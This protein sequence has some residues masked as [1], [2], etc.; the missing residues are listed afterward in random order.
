MTKKSRQKF[1]YLENGES[2]LGE[3]KNIFGFKRDFK[4]QKLSQ[5]LVRACKSSDPHRLLLNLTDKI[6]LKRYNKYVALS[7]LIIYYTRKDIKKLIQN[8]KFKIS[9]LMWNDKFYFPNGS[10]SL[11][12]IQGYFACITKKHEAVA[13]TPP[14]RIN[15]KKDI[16]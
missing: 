16:K 9:V 4:C 12:D 8:N 15:V 5:T 14:R 3:I 13:Y 7:N 2:F 1:K 11:S 10:Y 6:N